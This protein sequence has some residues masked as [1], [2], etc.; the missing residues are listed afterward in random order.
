[1]KLRWLHNVCGKH[2][3]A[4]Q[5][6]NDCRLDLPAACIG[7]AGASVSGKPEISRH[8]YQYFGHLGG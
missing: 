4:V 6:T 3:L 5:F 8:R 1:M 7:E 2:R